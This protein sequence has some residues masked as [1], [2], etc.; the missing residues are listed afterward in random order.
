M[1]IINFNQFF[2]YFFFYCL[3]MKREFEKEK[4]GEEK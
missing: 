2:F 4:N 1:V 3:E